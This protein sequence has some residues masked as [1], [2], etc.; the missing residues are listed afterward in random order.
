MKTFTD[1][2]IDCLPH[3]PLHQKSHNLL[4]ILSCKSTK[5]HNFHNVF[6]IQFPDVHYKSIPT[7]LM[8]VKL[9]GDV[10]HLKYYS[11][12]FA[13]TFKPAES[14]MMVSYQTCGDH[15]LEPFGLRLVIKVDAPR[16]V[17]SWNREREESK[18]I[19]TQ[20]QESIIVSLNCV[21][22]NRSFR[23]DLIHG[24]KRSKEEMHPRGPKIDYSNDILFLICRD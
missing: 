18:D 17:I 11:S 4:N 6:Q 16:Q 12:I 1:G 24:S 21:K 10:T 15:F 2:S 13:E 9:S 5:V 22:E 20:T 3:L 7:I 19:M 8:K 14:R 23:L